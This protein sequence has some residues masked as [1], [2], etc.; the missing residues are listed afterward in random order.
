MRARAYLQ[1]HKSKGEKCIFPLVFTKWT[2]LN[3]QLQNAEERERERE[4]RENSWVGKQQ[5]R[6]WADCSLFLRATTA[7]AAT[8]GVSCSLFEEECV[9]MSIKKRQKARGRKATNATPMRSCHKG[10]I[11]CHIWQQ[12]QTLGCVSIWPWPQIMATVILLLRLLLS[13]LLW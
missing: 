12:R 5:S 2:Q 4:K 7:V 13:L 6:V 1:R 9:K 3:K 10:K 11:Y 8:A